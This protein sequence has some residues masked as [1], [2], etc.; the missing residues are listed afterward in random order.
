MVDLAR[1]RRVFVSLSVAA[2]LGLAVSACDSGPAGSTQLGPSPT[3]AVSSHRV[4]SRTA[5]TRDVRA[6]SGD[7]ERL[8]A[9]IRQSTAKYHNIDVAIAD[10]YVVDEF[11]CADATDFGLDPSVGGMGLHLT[12]FSL[13]GDP[14]T[15]PLHPD[16]LVY[17]PARSPTGKPKL[18][19]IEYEVFRDAWWA[20]GNTAPP[21]LLGHEF[22]SIDFDIWHVFGLHVW[23]WLDNPS[24]MFSD[25][26]PNTSCH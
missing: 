1:Q 6:A 8:L 14:A 18:V 5:A 22:E 3:A 11:G 19:A 7:D 26:N 10:G 12:N 25:F 16:V 23:L 20:A 24:G 15:D 2:A 21:S 9:A 17:E 4:G 13:H